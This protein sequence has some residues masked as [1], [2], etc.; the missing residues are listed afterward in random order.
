VLWPFTRPWLSVSRLLG[1]FW[2][3]RKWAPS[4]VSPQIKDLDHILQLKHDRVVAL[5]DHVTSLQLCCP[6]RVGIC[7]GERDVFFVICL[8][9]ARTRIEQLGRFATSNEEREMHTFSG[10]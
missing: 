5:H 9:Y 2:K 10:L 4:R 7:W 6:Y 8:I 1:T 3:W